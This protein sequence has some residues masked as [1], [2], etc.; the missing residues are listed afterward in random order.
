MHQLRANEKTTPSTRKR[1]ARARLGL[2]SVATMWLFVGH[3]GQVLDER[4]EIRGL[5]VLPVRLRHDAVGE[6]LLDVG[7]GIGDRLL[8]EGSIPRSQELV[9]VRSDGPRGVCIGQRVAR[10]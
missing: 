9:E 8:D 4:V 3:G 6:A 1:K 7:A 5:D 2:R 10:R